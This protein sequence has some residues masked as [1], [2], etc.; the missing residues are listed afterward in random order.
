MARV[1]RSPLVVGV[2]AV[3]MAAAAV[4]VA[5]PPTAGQWTT[6]GG[7]SSGSFLVRGSSI[8]AA[9]SGTYKAITAPST[10]KCNSSNLVVRTCKIKIL[11]VKF[12]YDGPA[13]VDKFRAKTQIGHLRW[14]GTFTRAAKVKTR[15]ASRA[16]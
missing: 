11:Q 13:Y 10:F 2:T 5:A 16:T 1:R 6:S 14:S 15:S 12:S 4:A 8:V 9:G 7:E 3:A